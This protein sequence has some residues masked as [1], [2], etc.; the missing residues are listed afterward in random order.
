MG[1]QSLGYPNI[2]DVSWIAASG[3]RI[4][5]LELGLS[6]VGQDVREDAE[7]NEGRGE[8]ANVKDGGRHNRESV[9]V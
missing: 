5:H 4:A 1:R 7:L 8:L 6:S 3:Q 9:C 2:P